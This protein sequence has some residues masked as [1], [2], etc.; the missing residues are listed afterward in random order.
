MADLI[1][2]NA[3]RAARELWYDEQNLGDLTEDRVQGEQR[4]DVGTINLSPCR[5]RSA[6]QT[7]T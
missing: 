2:Q 1:Y 6:M 5:W 3:L 7:G 4:G